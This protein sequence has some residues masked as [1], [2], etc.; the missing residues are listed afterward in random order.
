MF[1]FDDLMLWFFGG[2]P[3]AMTVPDFFR[4]GITILER[5]FPYYR[6]FLIGVG[7]AVVTFLWALIEKTKIG[8]LVRS[9]VDDEETTRAMGINVNKLFFII[10]GLG[11]FLAAV[12]G[13]LGAP[14]LGMEPRM[15]FTLMP[16][17]LAVVI[18]GG[19]GSLRGSFWGSMVVGVLNTFGNALLPDFA[20]V[21]LFLPMALVL[22]FKPNGLF[23]S[24]KVV[25]GA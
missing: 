24:G 16:F 22:V 4:G 20:Y 9:G 14:W 21:V 25:E 10:F 7:I 5:S 11:T 6:L 23:V 1:F 2:L 8:C 17:V 12:G 13:F 3:L 18:I 15:A 19:L